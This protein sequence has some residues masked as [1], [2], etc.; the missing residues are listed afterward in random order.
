MTLMTVDPA[1]KNNFHIM[2]AVMHERN[3][4]GM[5]WIGTFGAPLPGYPFSH[6]NLIILS[7]TETG[8]PLAVVGATGI[9]AMRT[10]GGHGVVQAKLLANPDQKRLSVF[11]CGV[12]ARS[13]ICGFLQQFRTFS[14]CCIFSRSEEPIAAVREQWKSHVEVVSC[15]SAEEALEESNLVL[16]ASGAWKPL[17]HKEHL[18][19]GMTII[20]IEGFRDM[21]PEI[22]R[23]AKWYLGCRDTD[24]DILED[25]ELNPDGSLSLSDVYGD[26]AQVL[27]GKCG[28]D[29]KTHRRL[30]F[31][32]IWEWEHMICVVHTGLMRE[33]KKKA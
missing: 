29:G 26:V 30:L 23:R 9:T 28:Q 7:S 32:P 3:I 14:R 18:R 8:L 1:E 25:P 2:P 16:M 12:Q 22:S 4:A 10:A 6:G 15:H 20:G 13:G 27:N 19:P 33:R 31:Q 21:D 11:G 24:I 5:K 17:L